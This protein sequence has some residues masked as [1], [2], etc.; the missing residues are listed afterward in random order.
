MRSI[1]KNKPLMIVEYLLE[2][3]SEELYLSDLATNLG[4]KVIDDSVAQA[5]GVST[6]H[7]LLGKEDNYD[8]CWTN[9]KYV[10]IVEMEKFIE[11]A[12]KKGA[13][14][15]DI[16]FHSDHGTYNLNALRFRMASDN[17]L[18]HLNKHMNKSNINKLAEL[19]RQIEKLEKEKKNILK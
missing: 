1:E 2:H 15:L 5:Y 7:E 16:H 8:F 17:E 4:I 3:E 19:N 13:T 6:A 9:E 18:K 14:H 12:K 10:S 11:L